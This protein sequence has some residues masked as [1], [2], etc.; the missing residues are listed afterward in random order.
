MQSKQELFRQSLEQ[1]G[2]QPDEELVSRWTSDIPDLSPET[3]SRLEQD[4]VESA[5]ELHLQSQVPVVARGFL[6]K[7]GYM[8][9][10]GRA[11]R[12]YYVGLIAATLALILTVP[13]GLFL[14]ALPW[15][16]WWLGLL[17]VACNLLWIGA[18][19]RRLLQAK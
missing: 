2:L 4:G 13:L 1:W 18:A 3:I 15:A 14:F 6:E 19:A 10:W 16:F 12:K 5:A 9:L 17:P 7:H 8:L 11:V